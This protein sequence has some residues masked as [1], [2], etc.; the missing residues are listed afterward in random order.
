MKILLI[1]DIHFSNSTKHLSEIENN[2]KIISKT[3][4]NCD[5]IVIAGDILN[6][7]NL[8]YKKTV[9]EIKKLLTDIDYKKII[10]TCGNHD[11][12]RK[13]IAPIF[14]QHINTISNNDELNDF[15]DQDISE[16]FSKNIKHIDSY[17]D[18][19]RSLNPEEYSPLYHIEKIEIDKKNICL[20]SANSCWT[21]SFTEDDYG[22]I[23]YPVTII[24]NFIKKT[25]DC[26]FKVF[27]TH[28]PINYFKEYNRIEIAK[29]FYKEFD[30]YLCG[31]THRT[32]FGSSYYSSNGLFQCSSPCG[33]YDE[34]FQEKGFLVLNI[35][36]NDM[37]VEV[38][39]YFII[40]NKGVK[41]DTNFL[42][43]PANEDKKEYI[44]INKAITNKLSFIYE[45]AKK[46]F[47]L[48]NANNEDFLYNFTNPVL[49]IE[50]KV[51]ELADLA[52]KTTKTPI[53]YSFE[54][55]LSPENYIIHGEDKSGK[56]MLLYRLYIEYLSNYNNHLSL[57]IYI[58]LKQNYRFK[59]DIPIIP[60]IEV[61]KKEYNVSTKIAESMLK[62]LRPIFLI[63]NLNE[64]EESYNK[65]LFDI[66]KNNKFIITVNQGIGANPKIKIDSKQFTDI[67]IHD[68][69]RK[70]IRQ[71]VGKFEKFDKKSS[72][73]IISKV[74]SIFSQLNINF[75]FWT[76]SLFL[77]IFN[78]TNDVN[79][80]NNVELID[81]YIENMLDKSKLA[82]DLK[83][84][85]TFENYKDF[86]SETAYYLLNSC[87]ASCYAASYEELIEVFT[88]F[89]QKNKRIIA[90]AK[91]IIDYVL[92]K[93]I[94]VMLGNSKYSFRLNGVFEYFLALQMKRD[95]EFLNKVIS[96]ANYFLSFKNEL[97]IYAGIVRSDSDTLT[98]VYL[99][100]LSAET[101]Y[102]KTYPQNCIATTNP[103]SNSEN[104]KVAQAIAECVKEIKPLLAEERD[105][106][107]DT[108]LPTDRIKSGVSEKHFYNITE[109]S[110]QI[111]TQHITTLA[112]IF[113]NMDD[114]KDSKLLFEI[115]KYIV[116]QGMN[117][118]RYIAKE[119]ENDSSEIFNNKDVFIELL[120]KFYPL[121]SFEYIYEC[122]GHQNLKNI[123]QDRITE[124][125]SEEP[126]N[127]AELYILFFM[128]IE[129][130]IEDNL[131][132]IEE[133]IN[134]CKH[135]KFV[136][137]SIMMKLIS[138]IVLKCD[139]EQLEQEL[140][141]KVIKVNK[142]INP[143]DK[144]DRVV[145][146]IDHKKILKNT[147]DLS[148]M[149]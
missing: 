45:Y 15:V 54:K 142:M 148:K 147:K 109:I 101:E 55:L 84:Q 52:K 111:F 115:F 60:V 35:N 79:I 144:T 121:F 113:R 136:L 82:S 90:D 137:L 143:S 20:V 128:I 25:K 102:L 37:T 66:I 119:I 135:D 146:A 132:V 11:I 118:P 95:Q 41:I 24:Q 70:Q 108:I 53:E 123:I 68:L 63:D 43:I 85:F 104:D 77:W 110:T 131:D 74:T 124:L 32:E 116:S 30:I 117:L 112:K 120:D 12:D 42:E 86:L 23:L 71:L 38:E 27:I 127:F 22:N 126:L 31:H 83:K 59:E 88:N 18:Y 29:L 133:A 138:Y 28:Y 5:I 122:L 75:N 81:L 92:D 106:F 48:H 89:K 44:A 21:S 96:T 34:K 10:I 14:K 33:I 87:S 65:K 149:K 97:E 49:R 105:E 134:I 99:N 16:Q 51:R 7:F 72:E 98:T 9:E 4:K 103:A 76:V 78:K 47:C 114:I 40:E 13:K 19:I 62:K 64:D 17:E 39:K 107:N 8:E 129:C 61:I 58:D 93:G 91:T 57:P 26:D 1:S 67:Y 2:F 3:I 6:K 69:T 100:T 56:S 139:D 145:K 36:T 141:S 140:K 94:I 46:I 73:E 80:N 130:A 50:D 125:L